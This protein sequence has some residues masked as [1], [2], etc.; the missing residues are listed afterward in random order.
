[1]IKKD[2]ERLLNFTLFRRITG[3]SVTNQIEFE[4][5]WPTLKKYSQEETG[6]KSIVTGGEKEELP[7][8][9]SSPVTIVEKSDTLHKIVD[10]QNITITQQTR[11]HHAPGKGIQT[12]TII[13]LLEA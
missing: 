10:N 9:K 11:D 8:G 4:E 6:T 2:G 7:K 1:V 3:R 5:D 12:K 13:M